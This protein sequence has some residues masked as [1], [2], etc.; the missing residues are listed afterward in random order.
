M[1]VQDLVSDTQVVAE[2]TDA[3]SADAG[4][5]EIPQPEDTT[6]AEGLPDG[7][8]GQ[9]P[10]NAQGMPSLAGVVD[11]TGAPVLED[12]LKD[13]WSVLWFYPMASTSG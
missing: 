6:I 4:A 10:P 2:T 11:S 12:Q 7:L 5:P 1:L 3:A 8:T 9:E 13:H